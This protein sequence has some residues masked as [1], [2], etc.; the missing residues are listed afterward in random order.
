MHVN[1]LDAFLPIILFFSFYEL[2]MGRRGVCSVVC[3]TAIREER[4]D[5]CSVP[6]SN[7]SNNQF[8]KLGGGESP[9][10]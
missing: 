7:N 6:E 2:V 8:Y 9:P 4:Y 3:L 5:D 10:P 1:S